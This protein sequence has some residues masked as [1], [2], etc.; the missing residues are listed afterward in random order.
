[1]EVEGSHQQWLLRTTD[2]EEP[3]MFINSSN[4]RNNSD[5][6]EHDSR[7]SGKCSSMI[8]VGKLSFDLLLPCYWEP[9]KPTSI[10]WSIDNGM[11]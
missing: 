6:R 7:I 4:S 5:A 2:D 11:Q 9:T 10:G 3:L 1:M 8:P